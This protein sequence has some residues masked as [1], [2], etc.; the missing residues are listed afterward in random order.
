MAYLF[1]V[2]L[3][4]G[5]VTNWHLYG[6]KSKNPKVWNRVMLLECAFSVG[7]DLGS[8]TKSS[9]SRMAWSVTADQLSFC[10]IFATNIAEL[11]RSAAVTKSDTNV[12]SRQLVFPRVLVSDSDVMPLLY[13]FV[14]MGRSCP[15]KCCMSTKE[16][17]SFQDYIL[18]INIFY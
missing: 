13:V 14:S 11:W 10:L 3:E 5:S 4:V 17:Y 16:V 7:S 15:T 6:P 2:G 9:V 18:F 8:D 12:I 1:S